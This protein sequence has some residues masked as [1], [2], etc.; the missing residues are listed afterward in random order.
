M[1]RHFMNYLPY[2]YIFFAGFDRPTVSHLLQA[3]HLMW[4]QILRGIPCNGAL[5]HSFSDVYIKPRCGGDFASDLKTSLAEMK[6]NM[7]KTLEE[8]LEDHEFIEQE[9]CSHTL[10][11]KGLSTDSSYE[12]TKIV[13]HPAVQ[14]LAFLKHCLSENDN[15]YY[16]HNLFSIFTAYQKCS[17]ENWAK[18]YLVL[19]KV[20]NNRIKCNGIYS[21]NDTAYFRLKQFSSELH[22]RFFPE[23]YNSQDV[24]KSNCQTILLLLNLYANDTSSDNDKPSLTPLTYSKAIMS[25]DLA[26]EFDEYPILKHCEKY[27]AV[28]DNFIEDC[29]NKAKNPIDDKKACLIVQLL[30][31]RSR[32]VKACSEPIC[33]NDERNRRVFRV[34]DV[35][36]LLYLHSKWLEKHLMG[37]LFRLSPQMQK[38]FKKKLPMILSEHDQSNPEMAK[39]GKKL[40]KIYGQPQLYHDQNQYEL[41]NVR[42]SIYDKI[43]LDLNQ[44]IQRQFDIL[45]LDITSV[46]DKSLALDVPED[47]T[48]TRIQE[49]ILMA[50]NENITKVKLN[51]KLLPINSYVIQRVLNILQKDFLKFVTSVIS[52][53]ERFRGYKFQEDLML[54]ITNLVHIGKVSKGLSPAFINILEVVKKLQDEDSE[55]QQR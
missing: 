51:L 32:F 46:T 48:P 40:R 42:C 50:V 47:N 13:A 8:C 12:F 21:L 38:Q 27:L 52:E 35:V 7:L 15:N 1:L 43:T 49:N 25:G 28:V 45:S 19:K 53:E 24:S 16:L 34:E 6:N 54:I 55:F 22:K 26:D 30:N 3:A 4:Q 29:I 37:E 39:L 14:Q 5:L 18:L 33:Y 11:V 31:W 10:T 9:E 17:S 23:Y 20:N 2:M 36:P 41:S 44:P